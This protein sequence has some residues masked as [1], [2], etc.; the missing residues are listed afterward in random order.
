MVC[1]HWSSPDRS[2]SSSVA[3]RTL[4]RCNAAKDSGVQRYVETPLFLSL[5][6]FSA[7]TG[8]HEEESWL[9]RVRAR[10]EVLR[11]KCPKRLKAHSKK[12]AMY[13]KI[14]IRKA[15]DYNDKIDREDYDQDEREDGDPPLGRVNRAMHCNH[16][17]NIKLTNNHS[18]MFGG[19]SCQPPQR[20]M[21]VT[22]FLK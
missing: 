3:F 13:S 1:P 10:R 12:S 5:C 19:F 21:A 16:F 8:F 4:W 9:T 7:D 20:H 22:I 15:V 11:P 6:L 2:R 14:G 18:I 17:I